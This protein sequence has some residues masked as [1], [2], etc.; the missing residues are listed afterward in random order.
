MIVGTKRCVY[1]QY[2]H[3]LVNHFSYMNVLGI[4]HV[5]S[6]HMCCPFWSSV[7]IHLFSS[8]LHINI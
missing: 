5:W 2:A 8:D 1:T 6:L 4:T 3:I 7:S